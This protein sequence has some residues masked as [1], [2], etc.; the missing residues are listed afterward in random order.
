MLTTHYLEEA[1][2]LANE[3]G[4]MKSGELVAVGTAEDIIKNSGEQDFES[5]FLALCGGEDE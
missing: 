3:I 1:V 5:A 4:L 2:S